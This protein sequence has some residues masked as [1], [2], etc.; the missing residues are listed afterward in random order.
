MQILSFCYVGGKGRA[1]WVTPA[2]KKA[3][4]FIRKHWKKGAFQDDTKEWVIKR[5][6]TKEKFQQKTKREF[7]T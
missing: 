2:I 3:V 5:Q 1:V 7:K 6:D 4:L